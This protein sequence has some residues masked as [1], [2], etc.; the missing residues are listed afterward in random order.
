M[1]NYP[2]SVNID[3]VLFKLARCQQELGNNKKAKELYQRLA[4]E[5]PGTL[6]GE[7]AKERLKDFK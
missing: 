7:E 5:Y 4:D 3:L 2:N 6:K 1:T